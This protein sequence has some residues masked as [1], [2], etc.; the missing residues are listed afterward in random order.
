VSGLANTVFGIALGLLAGI[1]L[2]LVRPDVPAS[3]PHYA[4]HFMEVIQ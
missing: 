1:V 2:G 4:G 3:K